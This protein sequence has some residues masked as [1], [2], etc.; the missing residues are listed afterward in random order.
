MTKIYII[1][2]ESSGDFIGSRIMTTITTLTR[3]KCISYLG[4]G[5]ALMRTCGLNSLFDI[6]N[7]NLIGLVEIVPHIFEIKKLINQTIDDVIS[8]NPDILITIDSPGFTYRVAQAVRKINPNIKMIHIVAPSVWAYKPSR[9]LKY[10]KIYNHLIALLPFEPPYFEKLGLPTSYVGYF[11]LEQKFCNDKYELRSKSDF[12]QNDTVVCVTLGSRI[13]EINRHMPIFID[14]LGIISEKIS[15]LKII[16][17]V[18]NSR[19][20][21]LIKDFLNNSQLDFVCSQDK[22]KAFALADVA[23]A[24]SG[25]NTLEIAAS[26][27]P[28]VI[29]YKLNSLTFA[30]LRFFIKIKYANI[31][32]IIANRVIIP[33]FIQK[34]CK[35]I[36]IANKL[37][38]L[39]TNPA[40]RADQ[41]QN[42]LAILRDLG[43]K[44]SVSPSM[45]TAQII[46][47]LL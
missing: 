15:N 31:I 39:L 42:N 11:A 23:L 5:G 47:N 13:S 6:S 24:K 25:T 38:E 8:N 29:A 4:I 26:N 2:G 12:T 30:I 17:V 21:Q 46:T 28:M 22:L 37:L 18:S 20:E 41:I 1:A 45:K 10:A 35:S 43:F 32:N 16:F 7:I 9:A 27:T 40:K 19:H 14:A 44:A 33:E 3:N 36:D 34:N